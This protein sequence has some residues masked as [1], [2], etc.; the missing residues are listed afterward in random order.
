MNFTMTKQQASEAARRL[1]NKVRQP[2]LVFISYHPDYLERPTFQRYG[3]TLGIK[4]PKYAELVE[5]VKPAA[6]A[7]EEGS[8][9]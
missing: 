2:V 1:A 7:A 4:V 3:I 6:A 9:L 5:E 8:R